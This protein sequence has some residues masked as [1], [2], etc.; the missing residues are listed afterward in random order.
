MN[1]GR[2]TVFVVLGVVAVIVGAVAIVLATDGRDGR[3]GVSPP[4][5]RVSVLDPSASDDPSGTALGGMPE[6]SVPVTTDARVFVERFAEAVW[7]YDSRVST[8][9]QWRE[10]VGNFAGPDGPSASAEVARALLPTWP[11]WEDLVRRGAHAEIRAVRIDEP[12]EVAALGHDPRAPAG[13]RG[14]VLRAVEKVT[15]DGRTSEASRQLSVAVVC[16]PRCFLWS[17]TPEVPR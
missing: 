9:V 6:W 1:S 3:T 2:R 11:Q 16:L 10:A 12:P 17:A 14:F 13:W 4:S 5:T 7:T 8:Y 15:A